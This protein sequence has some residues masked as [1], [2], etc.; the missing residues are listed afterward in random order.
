[1]QR[2]YCDPVYGQ[3]IV[4]HSG[5]TRLSLRVWRETRP[6]FGIFTDAYCTFT[7]GFR[8][9]QLEAQNDD[10]AYVVLA[11]DRPRLILADDSGSELWLGGCV[12]GYTGEGAAGTGFVLATEGFDPALVD[13]VPYAE[14]LHVRK[15][16]DEPL[17]FE[18]HD[19]SPRIAAGTWSRHVANL[20]AADYFQGVERS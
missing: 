2:R 11:A 4:E 9:F 20:A 8:R 6:L 13:L 3:T 17:L 7:S 15:G 1:M 14:R 12:S 19:G 5:I 10:G 18:R 16:Y